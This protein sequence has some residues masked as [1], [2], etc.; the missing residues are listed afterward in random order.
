MA[1]PALEQ[2]MVQVEFG[3]AEVHKVLGEYPAW[4]QEM[5]ELVRNTWALHEGTERQMRETDRQLR[6]TERFIKEVAEEGRLRGQE[7]DRRFRDTERF[8]KEVAEEGRL[9]GQETDRQIHETQQ[10]I[11]DLRK[12]LAGLGQKFGGFAEGMAL[13]SM[14]RCLAE[15]FGTTGFTAR[16]KEHLGGEELY[17]DALASSRGEA[18]TVCVV[19]VKSRLRT[20][21]IDQLLRALKNFPRFF[22]EHRGK[23]LIGVLAAVDTR[24]DLE[25]RV[26]REGLVLAIIRDDVFELK[27][28][29]GFEPR[30][31]PNAAAG[32]AN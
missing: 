14:E 10:S 21:G 4:R 2:R 19:E 23:K 26:L 8:I 1:D 30:A 15:R 16:V 11:Q 3:L 12:E 13:P 5:Q 6:D 27:V 20:E 7:T 32:L 24:K 25:E 31:F 29:E 18:G 9:R 28:P 22:P 17:L